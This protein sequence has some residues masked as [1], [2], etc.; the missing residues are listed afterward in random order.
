MANLILSILF[1]ITLL[2]SQ[3][4]LALTEAEKEISIEQNLR[5]ES[6]NP[7]GF[8]IYRGFVVK[9]DTSQRRPDYTIHK[10]TF[11]QISH[12]TKAAKRRSTFFVDDNQLG[13]LSALNSDYKKSGYDRGHLVPAG[14]FYWNQLLKNETFVLSNIIPQNPTLNRGKW[15]YLEEYIRA[16]I[17][18]VYGDSYIVTGMIINP[19]N[20]NTIGPDSVGIPDLVY[21]LVY[22]PKANIMV[23]F[24]FNNQISTYLDNLSEYQVRI[25]DIENLSNED[26]Y[27]VLE[28]SLEDLLE[29]KIFPLQ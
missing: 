22:C 26:F 11:D 18:P 24:L 16:N 8:L 1:S 5:F 25:N 7:D 20:Y 12:L 23:G 27:D 28:D 15:A 10:L 14:D 19:N 21:K 4:T 9:Y 17:I 3:E 6:D 2:Y 13:N 29:S